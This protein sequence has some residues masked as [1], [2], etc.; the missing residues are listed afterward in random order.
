MSAIGQTS[1]LVMKFGGTSVGSPAAID[2]AAHIVMEQKTSWAQVVVVV[3]AMAGV[4]D[5]LLLGSR[6]AAT[7]D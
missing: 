2:Q 1:R 4:T 6:R 3:S 5:A 7:G